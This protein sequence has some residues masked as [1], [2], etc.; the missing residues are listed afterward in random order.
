MNA[1]TKANSHRGF[2]LAVTLAAVTAL[3]L[4]GAVAALVTTVYG[5]AVWRGWRRHVMNIADRQARALG[6][7]LVA[8]FAEDLR[9]G[10]APAAALTA[11]ANGFVRAQSN[12][13]TAASAWESVARVARVGGEIRPVLRKIGEPHQQLSLRLIAAWSLMDSGMSMAVLADAVETELR[14]HIR[15]EEQRRTQASSGVATAATLA[16]LPIVG[17]ALGGVLAA[18]PFRFL[19]HTGLGTICVVCGISLQLAG[20]AWASRIAHGR[21]PGKTVNPRSDWSWLSTR[22]VARKRFTQLFSRLDNPKR[23]PRSQL[24]ENPVVRW[25]ISVLVG[26]AI[27]WFVGSSLAAATVGLAIT[28]GCQRALSRREPADVRLRREQFT[29]WLPYAA[30]LLGALIRVGWPTG[31]AAA[32]VGDAIQGAVGQRFKHIGAELE[33]GASPEVWSAHLGDVAEAAPLIRAVMRSSES[34]SALSGACERLA[35]QLRAQRE[36]VGQGQAARVSLAMIAP[37]TVCFLPAFVLIGVVPL[38]A[39][40]LTEVLQAFP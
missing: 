13:P 17:V 24:I 36:L 29:E 14:G 27:A 2:P 8:G 38:I 20:W 34:G 25:V 21:R 4:S 23:S 19:L 10:A 11:L 18:Q 32:T 28:V 40:V 31:R 1:L 35:K 30:V 9:A 16:A 39:S 33:L 7:E 3:W 12:N 15:L 22:L 5:L 37:L 26:A 6:A